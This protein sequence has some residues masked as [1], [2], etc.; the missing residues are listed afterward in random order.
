MD[1]GR[2]QEL[3]QLRFVKRLKNLSISLD[4]KDEFYCYK[5]QGKPCSC[6]M[7]SYRKYSRK[8]KHKHLIFEE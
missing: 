1:K 3:T 4:K 8:Q 2:R 7:C 5:E 6:Y